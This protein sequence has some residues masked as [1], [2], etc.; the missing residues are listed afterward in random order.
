M[1]YLPINL[2]LRGRPFRAPLQPLALFYPLS[3]LHGPI[4]GRTETTR[5]AIISVES[6]YSQQGRTWQWRN[7]F[8]IYCLA[9]FVCFVVTMG[10]HPGITSFICSTQNPAFVRLKIK[11]EL[12][13]YRPIF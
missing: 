9:L 3:S 12:R 4:G 2:S 5:A 13:K 11:H 8:H 1:I 6:D 7:A 10:L